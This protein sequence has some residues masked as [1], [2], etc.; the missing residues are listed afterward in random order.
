VVFVGE[1]AARPAQHRDINTAQ[2]FHYIGA[3][4]LGVRYSRIG[5]N[6]DAIVNAPAQVFGKVPVDVGADGTFLL[7]R[8][9]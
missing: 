4:T 5:A 3:D 7:A 6:P 2:G 1:A 8:V 9:N